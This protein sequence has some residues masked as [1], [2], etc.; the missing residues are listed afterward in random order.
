VRQYLLGGSFLSSSDPRLFFS[1][2]EA[3]HADVVVEWLDGST[4]Q[5]DNAEAG[6]VLPVR[7]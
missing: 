1:L 4:Q 3:T 2:G 6:K 5:I 7:R